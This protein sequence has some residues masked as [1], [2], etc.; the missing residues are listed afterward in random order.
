MQ[1]IS[2]EI[3]T[4]VAAVAVVDAKEGAFGPILI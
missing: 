3:S 2:E 4:D 1:V